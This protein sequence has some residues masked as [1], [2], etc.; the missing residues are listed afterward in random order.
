[1]YFDND[2]KVRAPFDALNLQ[3]LLDGDRVR[4]SP[5]ALKSVTE[6]PLTDWA[7]WRDLSKK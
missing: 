3:R 7:R 5:S 4:R 1:V 2:V 6:T